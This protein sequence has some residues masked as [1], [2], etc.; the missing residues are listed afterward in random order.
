VTGLAAGLAT[1]LAIVLATGGCDWFEA[2]PEQNLPPETALTERPPAYG[3]IRGQDV[4]F[5]WGGSDLDGEVA[6]YE[7]AYD[8]VGNPEWIA[9]AENSVVVEDVAL[10]DHWFQVRAVDDRG[11]ADPV[12]EQWFFTVGIPRVV[13]AEFLTTNTCQN[14][15]N[16]EGGLNGLLDEVGPSALAVVGYHDMPLR[17]GLATDETAARIDWYT[18]SGVPAN[19]WPIVIF[20]GLS[21]V[22]GAE[23]PED[24]RV[25]YA[26]KAADRQA[27]GS[28][29]RLTIEGT[30]GPS[31]GSVA[32]GAKVVASL[33]D[34]TTVMQIVVVEDQV[35]YNGYFAPIYDFV[36]RD[37]LEDEALEI[38]A[39]GD[40]VLVERTF[41]ISGT[42]TLDNL[43]V[44]AFIQDT[45]T[46]EIIQAV[47]LRQE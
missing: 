1:G 13:L 32:V 9:T 8:N 31:E 3:L 37:L 35:R 39:I 26:A 19:Q 25:A 20:D 30:L 45:G 24:A 47:R 29:V 14:C 16:A 21:L 36:A 5:A 40:S 46:R 41:P 23:T 6:G 11:E 28:P 15:P 4:T 22:E 34:S 43:D 7:W 33:R 2:Q 27:V 10:G 42:W 38:A 44:V 18:A 12:Q 17:D